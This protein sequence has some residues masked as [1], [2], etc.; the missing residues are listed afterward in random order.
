M[1]AHLVV[2]GVTTLGETCAVCHW[3]PGSIY[4]DAIDSD[5]TGCFDVCHTEH[6]EI[7]HN[8]SEYYLARP[9]LECAMC[10]DSSGDLVALHKDS[11]AGGCAVCHGATVDQ[12]VKDA[13]ADKNGSCDACHTE[14]HTLAKI[15]AKHDGTDYY[16][17]R[18]NAAG[19]PCASCHSADAVKLHAGAEYADIGSR[20]SCFI[21]HNSAKYPVLPGTGDISC[22]NCH[23]NE[24]NATDIATK[25]AYSGGGDSC[26]N[27][28][29]TMS[30]VVDIDLITTHGGDNSCSL[31]HDPRAR[32]A[33]RDAVAEKNTNCTACHHNNSPFL[34]WQ[35]ANTI[36]MS[37]NNDAKQDTVHGGY[38]TNT[39]KCATCHSAHRAPSGGPGNVHLT[40]IDACTNC[41]TAWG[42]GGAAKLIEW[43]RPGDNG[44]P[45]ATSNCNQTC[46][47]GSIHGASRSEF[48][49]MDRYMLGGQSDDAIRAAL[50]GGNNSKNIAL[51][52]DSANPNYGEGAN[53]FQ[54]GTTP[55]PVNGEQPTTVTPAQFAA[56]KATATGYTCMRAE[57]HGVNAG[58]GGQFT[59]NEPGWGDA[60]SSMTGHGT[61]TMND[62]G[63]TVFPGCGPCHPGNGAGGYRREDRVVNPTARAY[64]CD[65]CHDLVGRATNS[66]AWPHANRGIDVYEWDET[67][68]RVLRPKDKNV[69]VGNLWMYSYTIS[70]VETSTAD[71]GVDKAPRSDI[72]G[73]SY[74]PR[75]IVSNYK[76]IAQNT[77]GMLPASPGTGGVDGR[78][79]KCHVPTDSITVGNILT[80]LGISTSNGEKYKL[81]PALMG[82]KSRQIHVDPLSEATNSKYIFLR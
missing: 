17:S 15:A 42:G 12:A 44:G 77:D 1:E 74:D 32:R 48:N 50:S 13:I 9:D 75:F 55:V 54:N 63:G 4:Q 68:K 61:G 37:S 35:D 14:I 53:W 56:A 6:G 41:H 38:T 5:A 76:D 79:L 73:L 80:D 43:A 81:I 65:Q 34:D 22:N 33:V 72:S 20:G 57:C 23:V 46:H 2:N 7:F 26:K 27:C 78:C 69:E 82:N 16:N 3:K 62:V 30:N 47:T 36:Y 39:V 18:G 70:Q 60:T 45:H 24:H 66:T 71:A 19:A 21:C 49:V 67:G 8:G 25:H 28:H 58:V 11:P 31:C 52:D 10:H 64:G 59:I 29:E 40:S 51:I